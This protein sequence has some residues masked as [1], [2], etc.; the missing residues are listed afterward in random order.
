MAAIPTLAPALDEL[1]F[2]VRALEACGVVAQVE[3]VLAR[4]FEYYSGIVLKIMA[5]GQRIVAGGRYDDLIG[6]V[7]GRRVPASGF[8]LYLSPLVELLSTPPATAGRRVLVQA[9]SATPELVATVYDVAARLRA[10]GLHVESVEGDD[11][12]PTDRLS[13]RPGSPGFALSGSGGVRQ[14]DA[15]DDVVRALETPQ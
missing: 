3:T 7:G 9:E 2:V 6:L 1:L 10:A 12:A 14:F 4:R 5:G 8:A 13:C 15:L 11:T